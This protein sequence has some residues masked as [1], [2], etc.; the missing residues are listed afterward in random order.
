M[1]FKDWRGVMRR[2]SNRLIL[3]FPVMLPASHN[4]DT[5]YP[6]MFR[7]LTLLLDKIN[8]LN[9]DIIMMSTTLSSKENVYCYK[10]KGVS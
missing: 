2:V 8:C 10:R 1:Q 5:V 6:R 3:H 4:Y 7:T 9:W